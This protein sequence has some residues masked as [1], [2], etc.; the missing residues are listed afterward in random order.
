[1]TRTKKQKK[2]KT[3]TKKQQK[4]KKQKSRAKKKIRL[5]SLN[6]KFTILNQVVIHGENWEFKGQVLN[7]MI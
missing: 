4:Q 2:R 7:G 5:I 6:Q 1:M 3:K